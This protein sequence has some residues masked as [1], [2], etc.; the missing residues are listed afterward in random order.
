MKQLS[1]VGEIATNIYV[2]RK[3]TSLVG[4]YQ[5]NVYQLSTT[6]N[7][8]YY[9]SSEYDKIL[10]Q[11]QYEHFGVNIKWYEDKK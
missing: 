2:L 6:L 8:A 9:Y 3:S 5:S 7:T 10:Q 1:A 4:L 11:Q